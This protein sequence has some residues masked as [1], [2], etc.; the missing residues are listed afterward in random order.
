MSVLFVYRPLDSLLN[1]L[2]ELNLTASK[3]ESVLKEVDCLKVRLKFDF[4]C[5]TMQL[6]L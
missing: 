2:Q 3:L 1:N 4:C 6:K 5:F